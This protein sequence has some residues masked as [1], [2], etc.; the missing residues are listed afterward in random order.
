MRNLKILSEIQLKSSLILVMITLSFSVFAQEAEVVLPESFYGNWV[1]D[2]SECN[3]LTLFSFS[4]SQEGLLV[5]GIDWYSSEVV[6]KNNQGFYN[7]LIQAYGE[8]GEFELEINL[9][10]GEEGNL[11]YFFPGK[12]DTQYKLVKCDPNEFFEYESEEMI[13]GEEGFEMEE[14]VMENDMYFGELN[15]ELPVLFYGNWVR[16]ISQCEGVPILSLDYSEDG[17]L[18]SGTDWYSTEVKV[19]TTDGSYTLTIK[20]LSE[21]EEFDTTLIIEMDEEENL[22]VS[23][24]VETVKLVKCDFLQDEEGVELEFEELQLI[25]NDI[26]L[27]PLELENKIETENFRIELLQGKWQSVEDEFSFMIIEGDRMKTYYKKMEDGMEDEL[28]IIS[29][30]CM[31]EYDS[32]NDLPKEKNRYLSQPDM[33]MCWYIDYVDATS[34]SLIYMARGNFHNFRRVE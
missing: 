32:E 17:V 24:G 22:M 30:T 6:V 33:D 10:M 25:T 16:D 23:E 28:I 2:L 11:I 13:L 1:E 31:N 4:G 18:V 26:E 8:E 15:S 3:G 19:S 9:K 12:E 34:L 5:S 14:L 7:L 27:L 29:D 20:G 21:E